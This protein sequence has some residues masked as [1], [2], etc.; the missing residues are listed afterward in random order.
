MIVH[1]AA[2]QLQVPTSTAFCWR[3]RFLQLTQLVKSG[4]LGEVVEV[5]KTYEFRS[6]KGQRVPGARRAAAAA[7]EHARHVQGAHLGAGGK[8][9]PRGDDGLRAARG[10]YR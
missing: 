6:Y 1:L 10:Q 7:G 5:D 4:S 8:R 9:P 2:A 3:H